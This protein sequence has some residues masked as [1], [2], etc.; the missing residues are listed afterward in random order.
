MKKQTLLVL[1]SAFCML[2]SNAAAATI[3]FD[4]GD[5]AALWAT[6]SSENYNAINVNPV[7]PSNLI[8]FNTVDSTGA[9]TGIGA[10]ASGFHVGANYNGTTA[11]T[12]DAAA[13][14]HPQALKDNAFGSVGLFNNTTAPQGS[15]VFNGLDISGN[16]TYSFTVFGSRT[17]VSD[18]RETRYTLQGQNSAFGDLNTSNNH[19]NVVTIAD[20]TPNANGT[21]TLLAAPGPNNNNTSGFWYLGAI[22]IETTTVPEPATLGLFAACSALVAFVRPTHRGC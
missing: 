9:P 16:T 8:L 22:R 4:L 2:V 1:A 19:S 5:A 6:P 3:F 20:I 14:F 7:D 11:P 13:I 17:G 21:I 12:G 10:V 15:V 18:N